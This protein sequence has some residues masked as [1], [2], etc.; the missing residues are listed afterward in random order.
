MFKAFKDFFLLYIVLEVLCFVFTSVTHLGLILVYDRIKACV[1]H[2]ISNYSRLIFIRKTL[3]KKKKLF[4]L[5]Q[6]LANPST[7]S[8]KRLSFPC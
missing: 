3:F 8:S 5:Y 2:K 6:S 7:I 1:S 4:I